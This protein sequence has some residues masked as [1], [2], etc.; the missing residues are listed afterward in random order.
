MTP[1]SSEP[2]VPR[3]M[4]RHLFLAEDNPYKAN[5]KPHTEYRHT[6]QECYVS[7]GGDDLHN[8]K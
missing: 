2:T 5:E 6:Y 7:D 3:K 1:Q 8:K 4:T